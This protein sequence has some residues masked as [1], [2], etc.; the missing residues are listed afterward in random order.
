MPNDPTRELSDRRILVVE[1]ERL[2]ALD[3]R[4]I[5]EEWGCVVLGPVATAAAALELVANDRP[6]CAVL[7]VQLASGTSEPI[8]AVLRADGC[9]FLILTAYQRGHLTGALQD[10]PM[11]SKPVDETKLRQALMSLLPANMSR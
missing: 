4:D 6:D 10:A 2:I 5:L 9:P 3:I 8:A 11:L 1:D 7:D